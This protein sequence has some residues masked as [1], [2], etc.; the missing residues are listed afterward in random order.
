MD[1]WLSWNEYELGGHVGTCMIHNAASALWLANL[2]EQM[3]DF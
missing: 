3:Q 2:D 1:T